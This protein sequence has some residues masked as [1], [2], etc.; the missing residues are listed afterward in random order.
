LENAAG[1]GS[2]W[3]ASRLLSDN[4]AKTTMGPR[5]PRRRSTHLPL[6]V[7]E[8][9]ATETILDEDA[10]QSVQRL[11]LQG[12]NLEAT[13]SSMSDFAY[14]LD[15]DGR[16]TYVNQS[17]LNFLGQT[18]EGVLGK[19]L[20]D[21]RFPEELARR[22]QQQIKDVIAT[23]NSVTGSAQYIG[24]TGR[25]GYYE[26]VFLPVVGPG[27]K[28]DFV[29]GTTH[30]VTVRKL[31]E[32]HLKQMEAKYRGLLDAAP[33]GIVV[34]NEIG[35][36]LLLNRRAEKQF[37]Y[38]RHE[39]LGRN[40]TTIIPNGFTGWLIGDGGCTAAAETLEQR[41]G[42]G[43]ECLGIHKDGSD[44][45][46]EVMLSPLDRPGQTCITASI[47]D[48]SRR[49]KAEKDLANMEERYRRLL[50][51]A[52]D[53][54]VVV[55]EAGD[56]IL[57]NRQA[58]KQ[59]GYGRD[60]LLGRKMKMIIPEGF[61]ERLVSDDCRTPAE[62]VAQQIGTGIELHGK[63]KDGIEFPI[64]IMLSP[65]ESKDG[66]LI[67]AAIR[68]VSERKQL[69]RQLQQSQKMDAIGRLTGGIAHDFNN[70]LTVII[71]NL[72]LLELL[73]SK[74]DAAVKR[75]K[76]AQKAADRGVDL[77]RRLLVFSRSDE[78]DHPVLTPLGD[79]IQNIID[80]AYRGLGSN[81]LITTQIDRTV[82]PI[83]VDPAAFESALL[84]LLV[85]ARDAMPN[86]GGVV[87]SSQRAVL[88]E[89]DLAVKAGV[90]K[91]SAYVCV[92]VTDQG[93]GMLPETVQRAFEPFFTTKPRDKG[94]GLGLA[95]V[96]GFAKQSG[97]IAR[98]RSE[99]G[100]GT[101]VSMYLPI[102]VT[103]MPSIGVPLPENL[104]VKH[105]R[106]VLVADDE[107]DA[108]E[109]ALTILKGMG[110]YVKETND[111]CG[112][113]KTIVQCPE[114][115]LLIA[116]IDLHGQ[117][118]T[119]ELVRRARALRPS[120][121]VVYSARV[122]SGPEAAKDLPPL[123]G[124][125]VHKPYKREELDETIRSLPESINLNP[126]ELR[127]GLSADKSIQG[128]GRTI[129]GKQVILVIDDDADIGEFVCATSTAMGFQCIATQDAPTFLE[130]MG[131]G[132][133][134]I[135]LDLMMPRL[136]GIEL[137]RELGKQN[138]KAD[139]VLMSSVG[140]QTMASAEQLARVLG[141]S[142]VGQLHKPFQQAELE[143]VLQGIPLAGVRTAVRSN[144]M[145]SIQKEDL[146]NAI[147]RN[148]FVVFYQPQI[149]IATRRVVGVE[150]LVR[151]Q[152]PKRGL[153]FPDRF[154]GR[155]EKFGLIDEL[156]WIVADR[157]M[158]DLSK[159]AQSYGEP[160]ALSLNASVNS[161]CDLNFPDILLSIARAHQLSPASITIEVTE[162][163]II[164][165]LPR[166]LD[167]LT[168]LRMKQFKLSIDDF[169]TGYAMMK[170][171]K[172][173]PATE[174]KIDKC[175]VQEMM[176]NNRDQIMVQK[177]IE[178]GHELGMQVMAEGVET[179]QQM[180]FLSLHDC[181]GAQGYLFSRPIPTTEME[182]WLKEYR[183]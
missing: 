4:R 93:Q 118:D 68:D 87:V 34:V 146:Q 108:L 134:L 24:P 62:A 43:I 76:T 96:Y 130:K 22:L 147:V 161:L 115:D 182:R 157:G 164:K 64:E 139:I 133:T 15:P 106:T 112:A 163:G 83:L 5:K 166:T 30:D 45:H 91:P 132:T 58:E 168:R 171:F 56:I 102:P 110:M 127:I 77:T 100:V 55:N 88:D 41:I 25:L 90:L 11:E 2:L 53:G 75:I 59:F 109:T 31:A 101:A 176:E 145:F 23:G 1:S 89:A 181:D 125:F 42:A 14:T 179:Q 122:G 104:N 107:P 46:I 65:M 152:Q 158:S 155:M 67:T 94:T 26:Y 128:L 35:E 79:S 169:G 180:D 7:V 84:N 143:E 167:I 144:P 86:G 28:I 16:V 126:A 61:A 6:S 141:L 19:N 123:D 138:C 66:V 121:K 129:I 136:D 153:I 78:L 99:V 54:M 18:S 82:P 51:A 47:R 92:T 148:E 3:M 52:P 57:L 131:P 21:L 150:A 12:R 165:E 37:G 140:K 117:F 142:V 151:W 156:G 120:M 70:L 33:D 17:L 111:T 38:Q 8:I 74:N 95:M 137:L 162:T 177:T 29:V 105:V 85:N 173:I 27:G 60:E 124:P 9:T 10:H 73:V 175:F 154:I 80:M 69:T 44:V 114:I 39:L 159:F 113:L 135:L 183:L 98:I 97:G 116:D 72:G 36:I 32:G 172:T 13:L 50:E 20:F 63:R 160:C 170:Q 119:S 40:I 48:I 49:K 174:L 71:G 149:N 103:T 178:M 81:I